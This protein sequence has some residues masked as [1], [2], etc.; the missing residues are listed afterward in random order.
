MPLWC[1]VQRADYGYITSYGPKL[2]EILS[3]PGFSEALGHE[4]LSLVQDGDTITVLGK[5]ATSGEAS[6][7]AGTELDTAQQTTSSAITSVLEVVPGINDETANQ[8]EVAFKELTWNKD[9]ASGVKQEPGSGRDPNNDETIKEQVSSEIVAEELLQ[10]KKDMYPCPYEGCPKMYGKEIY[11]KRC[12]LDHQTQKQ[13]KSYK[14]RAKRS[15]SASSAGKEMETSLCLKSDQMSGKVEDEEVRL[16]LESKTCRSSEVVVECKN[17][18]KHRSSGNQS[19]SEIK[20]S[21]RTPKPTWKLLESRSASKKVKC[22]TVASQ[23]PDHRGRGRPKRGRGRPRK[24]VEVSCDDGGEITA[25]LD[26]N[27]KYLESKSI[28]GKPMEITDES[29]EKIDESIKIADETME[30]TEE[31]S[32]TTDEDKK[33]R[34]KCEHNGCKRSY[35]TS[36]RRRG[37]RGRKK[38]LSRASGILCTHD[39]CHRAFR[40]MAARARHMQ[41]MHQR[42]RANSEDG[43]KKSDNVAYRCKFIGCGNIYSTAS[44]L[45]KHIHNNEHFMDGDSDPDGIRADDMVSSGDEAKVEKIEHE[46]VELPPEDKK[47]FPCTYDN[48]GKVF[49]KIH[50]LLRHKNSHQAF[51]FQCH[52]DGC[53]KLF[54]FEES[55]SLHKFSYH[56]MKS[57]TKRFECELCDKRF[58]SWCLLKKHQRVHTLETPYQCQDCL[59][60]FKWQTSLLTHACLNKSGEGTSLK[61]P[62]CG[63]IFNM[64]CLLKKHM[65]IHTNLRPF[66]CDQCDKSFKMRETLKKHHRKV[67]WSDAEKR[68]YAEKHGWICPDCDK[69]STSVRD[70]HRHR[71]KHSDVRPYICDQCARQFKTQDGL[72][73][74]LKQMHSV[75]L[76]QKEDGTTEAVRTLNYF[77]CDFPDCDKKFRRHHMYLEH[78]KVHFSNERIPCDHPGCNK[79]YPTMFKMKEHKRS[80]HKERPPV[81]CQ[82]CGKRMKNTS[83]LSNHMKLH[84]QINRIRCEYPGC[85]KSFTARTTLDRH[86]LMKHQTPTKM[87]ECSYEN[88]KKSFKLKCLLEQ[89]LESHSTERN[90]RCEI[91]N[92][93]YKTINTLR[94]HLRT[95]DK[96]RQHQCM[97]CG[98]HFPRKNR[99]LTHLATHHAGEVVI[100]TGDSI[101]LENIEQIDV[102]DEQ[103]QY[104]KPDSIIQTVTETV[105]GEVTNFSTIQQVV[106]DEKP[107]ITYQDTIILPSTQIIE[108]TTDYQ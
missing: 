55:L 72:N 1:V 30:N 95:H 88:C 62:D 5:D 17:V 52:E 24:K 51:P 103:V 81:F 91:C 43:I 37:V 31:R 89:H 6:I 92:N 53:K 64:Q 12:G 60:R 48:C 42:Q 75:T 23:S 90:Y 35:R 26:T 102:H 79:T 68:K 13:R 14:M 34:I 44:N 39:G 57:E 76:I 41:Q 3:Q 80:V 83:C 73:A 58:S 11:A 54:R 74:H 93:T 99:Y 70:F 22:V 87:Y 61:C 98:K 105:D 2:L 84:S 15:S 20:R 101:T 45:R 96:A 16:D 47:Q 63:K 18:K 10:P 104:L 56:G 49:T 82:I 32:P 66:K 59:Q 46:D 94:S 7:N 27:S 50:H 78:K 38:L 86:I 25:V 69:V 67:H 28:Q 36:L 9:D 106:G 29:R 71:T 85:D 77:A 97:L 19:E 4:G 107:D 40:T 33:Q 8:L 65:V 21:K 108:F 100:T